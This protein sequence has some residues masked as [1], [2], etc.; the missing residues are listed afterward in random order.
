MTGL[1]A[2]LAAR[3]AGETPVVTPRIPSRFEPLPEEM[4]LAEPVLPSA[5]PDPALAAPLPPAESP[6]IAAQ[7]PRD[8]ALAA[9]ASS[10]L[11][12][13]AARPSAAVPPRSANAT[14]AA[15][16]PVPA[17][18][19]RRREAQPAAASPPR[20]EPIKTAAAAAGSVTAPPVLPGRVEQAAPAASGP[21]GAAAAAQSV[22]PAGG[23]DHDVPRTD[24][25]RVVDL[26]EA[27][28]APSHPNEPSHAAAAVTAKSMPATAQPSPERVEEP[29][30]DP[31]AGAEPEDAA[32]SGGMTRRV[33][34]RRPPPRTIV[35]PEFQ[36]SPA[37]AP[38]VPAAPVIEI[39][40]GSVEVRAASAPAAVA[41]RPGP[42][43]TSLDAFLSRGRRG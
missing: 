42:A 10:E 20:S 38:V 11:A 28:T 17:P 13:G 32:V 41:P 43:P 7:P 29:P 35:V 15:S 12:P 18:L 40:I 14:I 8:R 36:S 22:V 23:G 19:V 2:R 26:T 24:A 5:E 1:L 3:S 33:E 27:F 37:R 4:G 25:P 16:A 39:H 9:I 21:T 34:S 6:V 30:A 31:A